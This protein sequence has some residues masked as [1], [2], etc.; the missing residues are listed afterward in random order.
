M[1]WFNEAAPE[2][3]DEG[4]ATASHSTMKAASYRTHGGENVIEITDRMKRPVLK[5]N[6]VLVKV[7]TS[8]VNPV[9]VKLRENSLPTMVRPLPKIIGSDVYGVILDRGKKASE[10][11]LIGD[12]VIA[13]MPHVFSGWGSAAEFAAIDDAFLAHAP[14]NVSAAEAGSLPLIGLTVLQAFAPFIA[15]CKGQTAGRS[16]LIQAGAGG[17]GTFA[18]QY[19]KHELEMTVYAT[20]S[21]GNVAFLQS[22]GADVVIDYAAQRFEEAAQGMDVVFDPMAYLYEDRTFRSAV[23]KNK[24]IS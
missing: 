4:S 21:A 23:L 15:H 20:C 14:S 9:D 11:F 10:K 1:N 6:Q 12:K 16:V 22:L 3:L 7:Y 18:I 5:D 19:C 13:M 17:L 8:G 24:V 2:I